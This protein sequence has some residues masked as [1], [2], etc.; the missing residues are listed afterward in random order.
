[1]SGAQ[2]PSGVAHFM[3]SVSVE[4]TKFS[5][6]LILQTLD[7]AEQSEL[8]QNRLGLP[9]S[10]SGTLLTEGGDSPTSFCNN[11]F[12]PV[13]QAVTQVFFF[14]FCFCSSVVFLVFSQRNSVS[15]PLKSDAVLHCSFRQQEAQPAESVGVQWRLQ[16]RGKGWKVLQM[17]TRLDGTEQ[18][19]VGEACVDGWRDGWMDATFSC[20]FK[21][22]LVGST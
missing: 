1:M 17:E 7:V 16:H 18:S 8:V 13:K 5:I 3:A 11:C 6:V 22:H 20:L 9:L 12:C 4:A 2:E 14:F 10:L 15:A 19:A 21:L